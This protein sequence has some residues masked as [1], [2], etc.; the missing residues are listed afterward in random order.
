MNTVFTRKQTFFGQ[1]YAM[2]KISVNQIFV[3]KLL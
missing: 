2:R 3:Y 1:S